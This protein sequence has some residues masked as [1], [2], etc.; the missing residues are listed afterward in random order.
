M[1]ASNKS[2]NSTLGNVLT[3][4]A[5]RSPTYLAISLLAGALI[6]TTSPEFAFANVTVSPEL[7]ATLKSAGVGCGD[8]EAG[9]SPGF[10]P[11][12]VPAQ[13]PIERTLPR[14]F[15]KKVKSSGLPQAQD[16][17]SGGSS[18]TWPV[19]EEKPNFNDKAE[20]ACSNKKTQKE[21][22]LCFDNLDN[23]P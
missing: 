17:S 8:S 16:W 22:K 5:G 19:R 10:G 18:E 7:C 9:G 1:N 21:R 13:N 14:D 3:E 20:R 2:L 4:R 6:G 15:P 11:G 23:L 12:G